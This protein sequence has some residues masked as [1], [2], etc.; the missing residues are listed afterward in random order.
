MA[1]TTPREPQ[2]LSQ[3]QIENAQRDPRLSHGR[4]AVVADWWAAMEAAERARTLSSWGLEA[5]LESVENVKR[6][7]GERPSEADITA[8]EERVALAHAERANQLAEHNAMTLISMVGALDALVETLVPLTRK[9]RVDVL[10]RSMLEHLE[11]ARAEGV[12]KRT[13]EVAYG[14]VRAEVEERIPE[15]KKR[16][17]TPRGTGPAR[18]DGPLRLVGL[19][20]TGFRPAPQDLDLALCEVVALRHVLAHRAGR[21]DERAL[22]EA[23][24][25]R[26]E[27]GD[28]VRLSRDDYRVYSAALRT[29]GQEVI[30][31]LTGV[32]PTVH[33]L[34]DWRSNCLI[35]A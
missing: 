21:V 20:P 23:P 10:T 4:E 6:S 5:L 12:D 25:L 26:Y 32:A 9:I 11:E 34:A 35:T 14:A 29:Y 31:R 33:N 19:G 16:D 7:A 18:W 1:H 15:I 17:A 27:D 24:S 3:R 30:S 22:A 8:A 13:V 28:L 2:S